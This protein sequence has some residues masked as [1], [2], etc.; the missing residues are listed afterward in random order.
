VTA[1]CEIAC[2]L[3]SPRDRICCGFLP[4]SLGG[5]AAT[6]SPDGATPD[7]RLERTAIS[8]AADFVDFETRQWW[9][10]Q[11]PLRRLQH[12]LGLRAMNSRA[13]ASARIERVFEI[14]DLP[15]SGC[16]RLAGRGLLPGRDALPAVMGWARRV[17]IAE[18][19]G[20]WQAGG[21]QPLFFEDSGLWLWAASAYDRPSG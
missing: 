12:R 4:H 3:K 6:N 17:R 9:H 14:A 5:G 16:A 7:P 20:K 13:R 10:A 18:V 8:L 19:L 21:A 11:S 1:T 15:R 2:C